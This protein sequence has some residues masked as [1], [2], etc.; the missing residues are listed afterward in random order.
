MWTLSWSGL[1]ALGLAAAWAAVPAVE[2]RPGGLSAAEGLALFAAASAVG[3]R[4]LEIARLREAASVLALASGAMVLYGL[5]PSSETQVAATAAA[6]FAAMVGSLILWRRNPNSHW[7]PPLAVFGAASSAA[8]IP[9]AA[10]AW[11]RR[12]LLVAALVVT[13]SEAAA[14]GFTLRRSLPLYFSPVLL[15]A[16]WLVY[17]SEA[18]RGNPQPFTVPIGLG[19]LALVELARSDRRRAGKHPVTPVLLILEFSGLGFLVGAALVQI[20]TT[21]LLYGL[22]AVALAGA[23]IG[24]GGVTRV[25]RRC[26][27]GAVVAFVAV[28]LMLGAPIAHNI[29]RFRGAALWVTVAAAGAVLIVVAGLL[30][31]GRDK[32]KRT[33][34]R[35]GEL[36]EGWE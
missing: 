24:W 10:I 23:V 27:F 9:I 11:P 4:P 12:G 36:M 34:R 18:L 20:V 17:A 2:R 31:Q 1:A 33:V 6:G 22:V 29:P 30:E 26:A 3:A 21:H 35:V 32:V 28:V 13:G 16:A 5:H 25:R 14:A 8:S 15:C 7:L 19:L